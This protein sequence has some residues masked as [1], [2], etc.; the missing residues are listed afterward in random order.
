MR[1]SI[2]KINPELANQLDMTLVVS[3][4]DFDPNEERRED[5]SIDGPAPLTPRQR[6]LIEAHLKTRK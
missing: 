6:E 2:S 5:E 4:V 3:D 1:I